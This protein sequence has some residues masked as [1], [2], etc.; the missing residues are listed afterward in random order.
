MCTGSGTR[1]M[2]HLLLA[3]GLISAV[4]FS[5]CALT[6]KIEVSREQAIAIAS[7]AIE[8]KDPKWEYSATAS[9]SKDGSWLVLFNGTSKNVGDFVFVS[10]DKRGRVVRIEGGY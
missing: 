6:P 3:L 7:R 10:V 8:D 4:P 2:K 9:L 1:H 5:G